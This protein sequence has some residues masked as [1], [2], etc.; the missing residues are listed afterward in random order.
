MTQHAGPRLY[1]VIFA[2]LLVLTGATIAA[3]SF[4]FGAFNTA[5]ALAIATAKASLVGLYFMH[6][7]W[8][9]Y[10]TIVAVVSGLLGLVLLIGFTLMD[11]DT[12]GDV[13]I[14]GDEPPPAL[15]PIAPR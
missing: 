8:S 5:I 13:L 4:D 7:R 6:L 2:A 15:A 1:L 12:R 9:R 10:L 3:A 14:Y 11:Y